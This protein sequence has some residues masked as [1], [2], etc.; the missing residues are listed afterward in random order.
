MKILYIY[1]QYKQVVTGGEFYDHYLIDNISSNNQH[2]VDFLTDDLLRFKSKYLY[3]FIYL[4]KFNIIRKY[5]LVITDSRLYSRLLLLFFRLR[6]FSKT[7]LISIHHHFNYLGESGIKRILHRCA[8]LTFLR[9]SHSIII[10]SP[11]IKDLFIK[12]LPHYIYFYIEPAINK[13]TIPVSQLIRKKNNELL[14]VLQG[15]DI[16][17]Q[18]LSL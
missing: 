9:L 11:Y 16:L 5:D 7:K 14:F 12:H 10:P 13:K 4:Q 2:K 18:N 15:Q 6:V 17:V 1:P 8:E 3:N